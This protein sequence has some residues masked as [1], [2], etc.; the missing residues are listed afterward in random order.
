MKIVTIN[1]SPRHD[2]NTA[3][4]CNAFIDG[5]KL[6]NTN[7]DIIHYNLND[8]TFKGCQSCFSCKKLNSK[9]YGRCVIK[10]DLKPV[11]EN[12]ISADCLVVATPI[13]LMDASAS[14]K[15]LLERLCFSLGSYEIGY[16]SLT[17]KNIE[18]VTLY[19]MNCVENDAPIYA[20]DNIDTFLGHI[21]SKP[22]RICAY[23]TYQFKDYSKYKVEVFDE[24]E[25]ADYHNRH[26]SNIK[27]KVQS[28]AMNICKKY[29]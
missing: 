15:A 20:M 18:V 7:C 10:D 5:T 3:N 4:L 8:I 23:N 12:I 11:L 24:K 28:Q 2:G 14:I 19:T 17:P 9:N 13:Y 25:K 26:W 22:H 6:V 29:Q 16:R 21:F 27:R 1:G